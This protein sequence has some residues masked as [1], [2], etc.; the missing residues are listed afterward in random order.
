M[1]DRSDLE[2]IH[3]QNLSRALH[4]CHPGQRCSGEKII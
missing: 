1:Y 3:F 4:S 2:I